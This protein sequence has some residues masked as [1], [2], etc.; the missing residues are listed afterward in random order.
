M[1][2]VFMGTPEFAVSSLAILHQAG[3]EIAAVVSVP[4]K[5]SGRGLK[6]TPSPVAEYA[7]THNIP[8]FKP[9]KLRSKKFVAALNALEADL[10]VVVAFR[11]LPEMVWKIPK[12][13]TFNLH[14]SLLPNYRG[15]APINWAIANGETVSGITT[16]F[17]DN[18][19][20]TGNILLQEAVEIPTEWNVGDLHDALK[21]VGAKL[22]LKTVQQIEAGTIEAKPQDANMISQYAPKIFREHCQIDWSQT[23]EKVH[24]LVRGMSP[25]PAAFTFING[26]QMKIFK[27]R[28]SE[29]TE[30]TAFGTI[31]RNEKNTEMKIACA[32]K[33]LEIIELQ[34]ESKKRMGAS[35]YLRGV[36]GHSLSVTI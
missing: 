11:M 13:G 36:Q 17:I 14:A 10:F 25:Y 18:Q 3:Y 4:D 21:E 27:T 15:A 7:S 22:V 31:I 34:P 19:I 33:Y 20:D 2:I 29:N 5:P 30:N 12:I 28:I 23:A 1:K 8:L 9:E 24:N 35:D 26:K 32:D 6:L 16:F